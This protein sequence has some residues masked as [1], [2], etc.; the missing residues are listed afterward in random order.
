MLDVFVAEAPAVLA[1]GQPDVVPARL[2]AAALAPERLDRVPAL[3]ADGHG[4]G[5]IGAAFAGVF[6]GWS[7]AGGFGVRSRASERWGIVG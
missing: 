4:V 6:G 3:D 2:V 5:I 7:S 1:H